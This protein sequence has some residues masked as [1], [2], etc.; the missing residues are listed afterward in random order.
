M[1]GRLTAVGLA[2]SVFSRGPE[3]FADV[4]EL[5]ERIAV[6][7]GIGAIEIGV[8]AIGAAE[9][10][11]ANVDEVGY[12]VAATVAVEHE[13][14]A[15]VLTTDAQLSAGAL[16]DVLASLPAEAP[17][18]RLMLASGASPATPDVVDVTRSAAT[19]YAHAVAVQ[20]AA[21]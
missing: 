15:V 21:S 7:L 4:H 19:A 8:V 20:G 3:G 2:P 17:K 18:V 6:S 16:A 14:T 12:S 13:A 1:S 11:L 10:Y 9:A 5:A